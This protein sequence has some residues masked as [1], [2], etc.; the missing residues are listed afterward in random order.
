MKKT[1]LTSLAC[2]MFV[3]GMTGAANANLIVNGSFEDPN[4]E[5]GWQV[6]DSISGW[7]T[8]LGTGIEI[9]YNG[10]IPGV[11][12]HAGNQ[13]VELDSHGGDDTNSTMVQSI[14][15]ILG[16]TYDVSFAYRNRPG[17]TLAQNGIEI[18]W[19]GSLEYFIGDINDDAYDY[20]ETANHYINNTN[21]FY[22]WQV[23]TFS[24]K[25]E[26]LYTGLDSFGNTL[27]GYDNLSFSAIGTDDTLGGFVDSVSMDV[28]EPA[29]MLL[30]GT[31]LIGLVGL[32]RRRKSNKV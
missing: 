29:T 32:Q 12:A 8:T 11:T 25:G 22:N 13:Y 9:Q 27:V 2:G 3:F 1:L 7:K 16:Q 10:V 19:N 31:G 5:S 15:T 6:F 28:P 23:L 17:T 21:D 26:A 24:V 30:F 18:Y 4:I 14:D 20:Y